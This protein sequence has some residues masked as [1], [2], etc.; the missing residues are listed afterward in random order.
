[1]LGSCST[2]NNN[3]QIK[4]PCLQYVNTW[5]DVLD[6]AIKLNELQK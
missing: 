6:C 1:M 2:I 5:G 3:E 4:E